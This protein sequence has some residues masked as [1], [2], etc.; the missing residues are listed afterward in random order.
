MPLTFQTQLFDGAVSKSSSPHA[1]STKLEARRH[2]E[3][4]RKYKCGVY[5]GYMSTCSQNKRHGF[6]EEY[7]EWEELPIILTYSSSKAKVKVFHA[8]LAYFSPLSL[9]MAPRNRGGIFH[10]GNPELKMP[11][12]SPCILCASAPQAKRVVHLF[13]NRLRNVSGIGLR[14]SCKNPL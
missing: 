14:A 4:L 11:P 3:Y 9:G 6:S 1:W 8:V 10:S 12:H 2:G 5:F 13:I 7:L